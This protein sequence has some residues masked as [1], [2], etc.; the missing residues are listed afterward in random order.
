MFVHL[1]LAAVDAAAAAEEML[2]MMGEK[3]AA[4]AAAAGQTAVGEF[5]ESFVQGPMEEGGEGMTCSELVAVVDA[6]A[7]AAEDDDV[8]AE[9]RSV[10]AT[11]QR[12]EESWV[13]V[14]VASVRE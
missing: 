2:I 1:P 5:G 13:M 11:S 12:M 14:T 7:A 4:A 6:D 3:T 8:E 9:I 10:G